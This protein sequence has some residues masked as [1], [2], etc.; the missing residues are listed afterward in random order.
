MSNISGGVWSLVGK[1]AGIADSDLIPSSDKK[2]AV[3][4][5]HLVGTAA[6]NVISGSLSSVNTGTLTVNIGAVSKLGVSGYSIPANA[7]TWGIS[8]LPPRMPAVIP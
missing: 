5:G 1:T 4:T 6:I 2:S 7:V 8:R 3:F